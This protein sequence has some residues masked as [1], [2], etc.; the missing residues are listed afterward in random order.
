MA[1]IV[2]PLQ[3]GKVF[4]AA[5]WQV[6][7][8]PYPHPAI[9]TLSLIGQVTAPFIFAANLFGFVLAVSSAPL[10]TLRHNIYLRISTDAAA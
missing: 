10:A 4:D 9:A 5:K 6:S 3:E 1:V 2:L 8:T 7:T